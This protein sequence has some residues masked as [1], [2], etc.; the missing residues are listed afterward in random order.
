MC[1]LLSADMLDDA[2]KKAIQRK[3]LGDF[4]SNELLPAAQVFVLFHLIILAFKATLRVLG[5][6]QVLPLVFELLAS[7]LDRLTARPLGGPLPPPPQY[8]T[9]RERDVSRPTF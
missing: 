9:P 5:F 1:T 6:I 4:R 8:R 7:W 3:F 2:L